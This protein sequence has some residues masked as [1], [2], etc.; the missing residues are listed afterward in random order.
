MNNNLPNVT[1]EAPR[2]GNVPRDPI[3]DHP[4]DSGR[5]VITINTALTRPT[6]DPEGRWTMRSNRI[7]R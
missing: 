2:E 5:R 6:S 4:P 1:R 7:K 3:A